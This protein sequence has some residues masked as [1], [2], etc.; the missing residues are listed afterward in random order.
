[1]STSSCAEGI[2]GVLESKLAQLLQCDDPWKLCTSVGVDNTS[3]NIG[4]K[5]SLKTRILQCNSPIFFNGCPC[6][7]IHNAA[8]HAAE[9]FTS[10]CGFDI[11]EF[12]VDLYYWF[13]KSTKRKNELR[14]Y[15]VFCDQEYRSIIKHIST[16]WLSLEIA[17]DRILRQF[18]SL[19]SYFLSE[20][21]AQQRFLRLQ[22]IFSDPMTEVNLMFCQAVLPSFTHANMF[23]QREEP[24]IHVLQVWLERLV[25]SILAKFVK[26]S[27][28]SD[29]CREGKLSSI[30]YRDPENHVD[31]GKLVVGIITEQRSTKRSGSSAISGSI[32]LMWAGMSD[33][34]VMMRS[35]GGAVQDE[36]GRV[37]W[38]RG[39]LR[40]L[41]PGYRSPL[42]A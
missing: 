22:R 16:R 5:N 38:F 15:C 27:V 12:V 37:I 3:V 19:K 11:E 10:E 6:H 33:S 26:P 25:K 14:S 23:L 17:V 21:E 28:I 24:L 9:A 8:Q 40:H 30:N 1:M 29:S 2:Y 32:D 35:E 39:T 13:D 20:D 36:V 41:F 34:F 4:I 42:T 7:I 18:P 31:N